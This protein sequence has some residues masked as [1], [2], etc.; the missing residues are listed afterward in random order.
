MAHVTW[1]KNQQSQKVA[2]LE[3]QRARRERIKWALIASVTANV[4]LF[5]YVIMSIS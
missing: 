3:A 4:I 1:Q 5:T 2:H